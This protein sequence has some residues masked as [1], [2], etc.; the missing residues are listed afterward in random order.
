MFI[1]LIFILININIKFIFKIIFLIFNSIILL[2]DN[3][4][5][6]LKD[7]VNDLSKKNLLIYLNLLYEK[8]V[9]N[10]NI[11][12]IENFFINNF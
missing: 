8:W 4:I 12:D 10:L 9:L 7:N 3:T 5:N 1:F 2:M 11:N 6:E